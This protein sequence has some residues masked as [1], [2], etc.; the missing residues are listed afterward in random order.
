MLTGKDDRPLRHVQVQ[1]EIKPGADQEKLRQALGNLTGTRLQF[2][3]D[4]TR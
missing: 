1:I 4:V 3:V 2:S